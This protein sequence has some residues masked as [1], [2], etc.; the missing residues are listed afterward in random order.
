MVSATKKCWLGATLL[1]CLVPSSFALQRDG[2]HPRDDKK[3]NASNPC[4]TPVPEGGSA[5]IYLLGASLTCLG[6][7]LLRSRSSKLNLS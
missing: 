5:A 3:C 2:D 4:Q 1:L 6:A 7:M